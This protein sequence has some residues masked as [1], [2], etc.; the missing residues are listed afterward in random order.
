MRIEETGGLDYFGTLNFFLVLFSIKIIINLIQNFSAIFKTIFECNINRYSIL[1][2]DLHE[3]HNLQLK[4][5]CRQFYWTPCIFKIKVDIKLSKI[6]EIKKNLH[7]FLHFKNCFDC[8]WVI[9]AS[10]SLPLTYLYLLS[11][12]GNGSR[13]CVQSSVS[14]PLWGLPVWAQGTQLHICV[15]I[16]PCWS[17]WTT[18]RAAEEASMRQTLSRSRESSW[19][20]R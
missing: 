17:F 12:R 19:Q 16:C 11:D 13:A 5:R 10:K 20:W 14:A 18:D 1:W 8:K 9:V 7:N 2:S 6:Y 15:Y 4:N 3:R